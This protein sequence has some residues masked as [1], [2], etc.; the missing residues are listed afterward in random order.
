MKNNLT[1][2]I[3][4]H[5]DA[6]K[7]TLSEAML[8]RSGALQHL[9]RVDHQDAFL[10]TDSLERIR[11]I[12]IFSKQALLNFEGLQITLM[13]TPG[14]I[15]FS[16]E[17]EK[18]LS[19]LDYALL[20]INGSDGIQGHSLTLWQLL[21]RYD[22]P[23]IIF[24]NK[25]DLP[26]T[27]EAK[28]MSELK[29]RL[30]EACVYFGERPDQHHFFEEIAVCSEEV[31]SLFL[32]TGTID[33][34]T[35]ASLVSK[36]LL[37][38]CYF[39]SALKLTGVDELLQGIVRFVRL[40]EYPDS[41][42]A[43]V[44]KISRD[45]QGQRL[46]HLKITG[47][48]L[49]TRDT[50][51][52]GRGKSGSSQSKVTQIRFY[53]GEKYEA[54]EGAAAGSICAV[55]GLGDSYPGQALGAET[56]EIVPAL[57]PVLNYRMLLPEGSDAFAVFKQLK[58]L[59]EEDPQLSLSWAA[60]SR[61]IHLLAMGEVQL[62]VLSHVI[63]ER[64]GLD[65]SFDTGRV[66]YKETIAG[67]VIGMGHYEPLKHYAEV[68]LRLEPL[69]RGSGLHFD[70]SCSVDI[71]PL[72]YQNL[73]LGQLSQQEHIGVLTGS[74]LTDMRITLLNGRAH[75]KH[76]VGGD[77]REAA[78]R[79][80]R[81]GLMQ[82]KSLLLEPWYHFS[83][84]LPT[85][86]LGR[87]MTDLSRVSDDIVIQSNDGE[88]AWLVGSVPVA[89]MRNYMKEIT[90]YTHGLG[91]LSCAFM[92]FAACSNSED[93]IAAAGYSAQQDLSNSA[94]SVFCRQGASVL[95]KWQQAQ[96]FMHIDTSV[97]LK[98]TKK[99]V[100]TSEPQKNKKSSSEILDDELKAIFER[101]YGPI[102]R[103]GFEPVKRNKRPDSD[104]AEKIPKGQMYEKPDYLLVDGYNIIHA[105]E[106][107]GR[108][109][110]D[111]MDA[112]RQLLMDRLSNY[113]GMIDR[114]IILVFDAYRVPSGI[115]N[116]VLYHN[117]NIVYT[118]EAETADAYI[119]KVSYEI[120]KK[121]RVW[122]ATADGVIQ[123][124]ALGH[125]AIRV[126]PDML[127]HEIEISETQMQAILDKN[128]QKASSRIVFP[129]DK[130]IES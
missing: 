10:D 77:F 114:E 20:I 53:S 40:P 78:F 71:L 44:F 74:P 36:R 19:V 34:E 56:A 81:Q 64:F 118:K 29:E 27:D 46:T 43:R 18:V 117:I 49:K 35:I 76:T 69:P 42:G 45:D 60:P 4:A 73:V 128:Y 123:L 94:D 57:Q 52:D 63:S 90:S 100:N 38:P 88:H 39:G 58:D 47:G 111:N 82:A 95:V 89:F 91:R 113:R 121:H 6:G 84:E 86:S 31:L 51:R 21:E 11:G 96:N 119:E 72:N 26:Q 124:I 50:V 104:H 129:E 13:D 116:V 106:E 14:H 99:Q 112:A 28:I 61:E 5:V 17:M 41:F 12:T 37:F 2:G 15:D 62:E 25:M 109:A 107:L 16:S 66:L 126:S 30:G 8:F 87:A 68:H 67:P 75:A 130:Q 80:L 97:Y 79:A 108:L 85:A 105:W 101:T 102:K 33:D 70:S 3:L 32:K 120:G 23:T 92:G 98:D 115:E 125:G 59:Q 103:R 24:I 93:V 83:L 7:T 1:I 110:Q 55:T 22:I 122:V 48:L 65:V 127:K 54:S 9:G